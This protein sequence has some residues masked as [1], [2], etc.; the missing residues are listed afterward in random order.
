MRLLSREQA[1]NLD[2]RTIVERKISASELMQKA[3]ELSADWIAHFLN[4]SSTQ[5]NLTK[6]NKRKTEKNRPI[7]FLLGPGN[8]AGDGK[9]CAQVL[10][11]RY[12]YKNIHFFSHVELNLLRLGK[13]K[14]LANR[15]QLGLG[16]QNLESGLPILI[17]DAL[18][19]I[20]LNRPLSQNLI[21]SLNFLNGLSGVLRVSLDISSGLDSNTGMLLGGAFK[22][23]YTLT[24]GSPKIGMFVNNGPLYSGRIVTLKIGFPQDLVVQVANSFYLFRE[25]NASALLPT[26]DVFSQKSKAGRSIICAGS[27]SM[28]GAAALSAEACSRMGAGYTTLASSK[29]NP[30]WPADFLRMKLESRFGRDVSTLDWKKFKG[31]AVGP[32]IGL[33]KLGVNI[34]KQCFE[35]VGLNIP[36]VID[37]DA[38]TIYSE[39]RKKEPSHYKFKKFRNS[40]LLTPHAGELERLIHVS[41]NEIERDRWSYCKRAAK[42]LGCWVLLK[43]YR[44]ILSNGRES[45]VVETGNPVLAKA[46]TGDVLTG[47]IVGLL[48]QGFDV[49]KATLIGTT[50][51][52]WLGDEW[53]RSSRDVLSLRPMDLIRGMSKGLLKFRRI[54]FT[55]L[56]RPDV[57]IEQVPS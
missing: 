38:L 57:D 28:P 51:H 2:A 7:I 31:A 53:L 6:F 18:F 40:V 11:I 41:S 14:I 3:G 56:Y 55:H 44:P 37:A 16:N 36:L 49:P 46:G 45:F 42:E 47:I 5:K 26:R 24:F 9:I 39:L 43:G 27:E 19:G 33:D 52:G 10:K 4:S 1:Q 54:Y 23:N 35:C 29:P 30:L 21:E 22:A 20:G 48:S 8:N 25:K 13:S 15:R 12:G 32:G 34:F 17:V 50:F